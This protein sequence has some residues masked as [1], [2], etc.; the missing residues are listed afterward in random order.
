MEFINLPKN[1]FFGLVMWVSSKHIP[2][3]A[4]AEVT[5]FL[6]TQHCR[7]QNILLGE[8]VAKAS[9]EALRSKLNTT[10]QWQK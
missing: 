5:R 4:Q 7:F 10:F 2:Q 1:A 3:K 8:Q 9:P 6:M